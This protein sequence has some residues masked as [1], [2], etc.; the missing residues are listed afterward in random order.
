[1]RARVVARAGIAYAEIEGPDVAPLP[2]QVRNSPDS[3]VGSIGQSAQRA[4]PRWQAAWLTSEEQKPAGATLATR[5]TDVPQ[6]H[7]LSQF[8]KATGQAAKWAQKRH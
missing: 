2:F 8:S 3:A 1:R 5:A 6:S 7:C 4:L